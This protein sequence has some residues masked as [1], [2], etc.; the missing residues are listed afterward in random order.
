MEPKILAAR[1]GLTL[2]GRVA[3][4]VFVSLSI[5]FATYGA[6]GM[7]GGAI[8]SNADWKAPQ[9]GV[10]IYVESNGIHTG[11]VLPVTAAGV[12][13]RDLLRPE[14]VR[15]P[16]YATY[17]H[18]SIG[19][20]ERTFY[21]E[22]PT[23]GDVRLKTVTAA[24]I[25]SDRTVMHVGHVPEPHVVAGDEADIRAITLRPE[26]YRRLADFIHASF[27][28]EG[29]ERP[30]HQYGY[31][32]Y[33]SFYDARGHYSA[34]TTCNAWTGDALRHAGVRVGAWT[35]FPVTVLGWFQP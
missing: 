5:L 4:W 33:D 8:P 34:I 25:G 15:D 24:A 19:W 3:K 10:R 16:R 17:N 26:E 32:V 9:S 7:A 1:T 2:A 20:G 13:W 27:K 14:D 28:A 18:V 23:W 31:D 12:D 21:L 11:L 30:V 29:E 35:P 6:A 22:T